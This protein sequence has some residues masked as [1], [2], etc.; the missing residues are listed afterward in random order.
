MGTGRPLA[1]AALAARAHLPLRVIR[2]HLA[3][4]ARSALAFLLGI[5]TFLR[6]KGVILT[7]IYLFITFLTVIY[8]RGPGNLILFH[9]VSPSNS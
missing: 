4:C 8:T 1:P 9:V 5:G 3:R 2:S 6:H 7:V